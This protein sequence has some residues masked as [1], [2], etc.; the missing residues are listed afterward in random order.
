[1]RTHTQERPYICQHCNKAFSR[2][3][4]LAQHRRIHES[5]EGSLDQYGNYDE[6]EMEGEDDQLPALEEA[7]PGSEQGYLPTS[8]PNMSH[9]MASSSMGMHTLAAPSQLV[10]NQQQMIQQ[11]I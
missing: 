4:N 9:N 2:S 3:D 11:H 10:S 7:S 8:M 5:K 1:M 6:E